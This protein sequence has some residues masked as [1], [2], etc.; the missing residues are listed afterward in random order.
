MKFNAALTVK[1]VLTFLRQEGYTCEIGKQ[2]DA[3]Q[4]I[5]PTVPIKSRTHQDGAGTGPKLH[6][7]TGGSQI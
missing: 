7:Q 5:T 4:S 6:N 1:D 2:S 3:T